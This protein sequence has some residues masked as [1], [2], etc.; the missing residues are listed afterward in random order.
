MTTEF[1]NIY[2]ARLRMRPDLICSEQRTGSQK[3]WVVKDPV[4]LRYFTLTPEEFAILNWL[5][6]ENSLQDICREF[7]AAF[8]PQRITPAHLQSFFANLYENGLIIAEAPDQGSILLENRQRQQRRERMQTWLNWLA[9]RLPRKSSST[10]RAVSLASSVW[11]TS[12][13]GTL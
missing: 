13:C 1:R 2:R 5:D 8:P 10:P 11:P 4:S 12:A 7:A 9:I 6:G 3:A